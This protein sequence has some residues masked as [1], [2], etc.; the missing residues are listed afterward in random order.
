MGKTGMNKDASIAAQPAAGWRLKLGISMFVLSIL[1][2]VAGIPLVA[3]LDL[4]GTMTASVS[5]VLLMGS[6]ILGILAIA[7]MGKPGFLY[8]K[9]RVFGLLRLYGPPREVSRARYNSGL[10]MFILPILF[11][12]LSIY[13]ADYIPL[14]DENP[15]AYA[16]GGD[17]L[18]LTSLFVLGGDF[19]DKIRALF[20]HSD[21]VC[22]SANQQ[23]KGISDE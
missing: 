20:V 15:L 5:G 1:L 19:W 11:G 22:A 7:V 12:W 8:M 23:T 17:L 3:T 2:P 21:K 10:V 13:T 18:L 4:S 16:I 6:E 9:S 14:Y